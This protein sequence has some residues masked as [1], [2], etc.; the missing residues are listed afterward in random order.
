MRFPLRYQCFL[1]SNTK[2]IPGRVT[3]DSR[4]TAEVHADGTIK[5]KDFHLGTNPPAREWGPP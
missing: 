5:V 2:Q 4:M 3:V 1:T